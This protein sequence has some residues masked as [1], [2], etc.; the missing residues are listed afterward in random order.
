MTTTSA[1]R[2]A[3]GWT[4]EEERTLLMLKSSNDRLPWKDIL[5]QF[6][7]TVPQNRRRT[8][9]AIKAKWQTLQSA[10]GNRPDPHVR[11]L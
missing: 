10:I 1:K 8:C 11:C 9:H 5:D 6:N 3:D 2:Q 4:D 7:R